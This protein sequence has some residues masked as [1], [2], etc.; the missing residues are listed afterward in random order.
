M[1]SSA[2]RNL[3]SRWTIR[4]V[5]AI[6]EYHACEELQRRA[7]EF[8]GDLDIVPLT[9]LVA[10]QKAG[11]I[12]LGGFDARG[13]MHGFCYGFVGRRDDGQLLK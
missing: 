8:G 11:G 13:T 9:Q 10:A 2:D 4:R 3:S 1:D 6:D 12:V 5:A 7:W